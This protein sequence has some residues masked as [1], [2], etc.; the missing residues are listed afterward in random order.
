[1]GDWAKRW[2]V[3]GIIFVVL[4]VIL[5]GKAIGDKKEASDIGEGILI[6]DEKILAEEIKK[7][8]IFYIRGKVKGR[9]VT[10]NVTING[11]KL[12]NDPTRKLPGQ[13]SLIQMD[14]LWVEV[15]RGVME[16]NKEREKSAGVV[17]HNYVKKDSLEIFPDEVEVLGMKFDVKGDKGILDRLSEL[18]RDIAGGTFVY[19]KKHKTKVPKIGFTSGIKHDY[20]VFKIKGIYSDIDGVLKVV[21]K[22]GKPQ[23]G[24][25]LIL[26]EKEFS[27]LSDIL[28]SG[29]NY[30]EL[31]GML[32]VLW[33]G[34]TM[35]A[36]LIMKFI[37][38]IF[39]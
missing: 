24:E 7:D 18:K 31:V 38:N 32:I 17:E 12:S 16:L 34:L 8:G 22:E 37:M 23:V 15:S 26:T 13:E 5:I 27:R 6:S 36:W 30:G 25:F 1:M 20:D 19:D 4:L 9:A 39:Y 2:I 28:I 14:L 11:S 35:L 10:D 3:S 21:V 33:I 29:I